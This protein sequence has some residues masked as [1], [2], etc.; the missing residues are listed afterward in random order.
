[1]DI[2]WCTWIVK[3]K[4]YYTLDSMSLISHEHGGMMWYGVAAPVALYTRAT[5]TQMQ[6]RLMAIT[7]QP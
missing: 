3:D 5:L 7:E 6:N 4:K 1:M 2:G